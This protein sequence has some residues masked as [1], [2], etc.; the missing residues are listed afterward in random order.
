MTV[1]GG[2]PSLELVVLDSRGEP[3][4]V[5]QATS[6]LASAPMPVNPVPESQPA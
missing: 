3:H 1:V 4:L 5:L 6:P 2:D